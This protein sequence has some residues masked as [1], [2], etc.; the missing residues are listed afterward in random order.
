MR[1]EFQ[2]R[3]CDMD[4]WKGYDG[5]NPGRSARSRWGATRSRASS[6][7]DPIVKGET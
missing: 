4:T 1:R 3:M 5:T 2:I 7:C 6:C